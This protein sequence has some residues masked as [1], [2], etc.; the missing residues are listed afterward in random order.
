M[1]LQSGTHL[2]AIVARRVK[3][4]A[5]EE[6]DSFLLGEGLSLDHQSSI[7]GSGNRIFSHRFAHS[8]AS[9]EVGYEED[10]KGKPL[11]GGRAGK[12]HFLKPPEGL[13]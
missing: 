4:Q 3:Q 8:A 2:R 12:S 13:Q 6:I 7:R 10:D 5:L 9:K 11:G 1:S